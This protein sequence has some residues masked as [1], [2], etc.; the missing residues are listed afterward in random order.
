[1]WRDITGP[2]PDTCMVKPDFPASHFLTSSSRPAP[3]QP[4]LES[5]SGFSDH[6]VPHRDRPPPWSHLPAWKVLPPTPPK[7]ALHWASLIV[8][9]SRLPRHLLC[10][11]IEL[12]SHPASGY[13]HWVLLPSKHWAL[14]LSKHWA[15]LLSKHWVL[16]LSKHWVLLL[17]KHWVLLLSSKHWVLSL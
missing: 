17:S 2:R 1:M 10:T 13:K 8:L 15:L 6:I 11:A 5:P 3:Q 14:V 9:T 4:A 7:V 12:L 16:L